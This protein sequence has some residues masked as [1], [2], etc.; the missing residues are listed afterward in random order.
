V[1]LCCVS[2]TAES[3]AGSWRGSVGRCRWTRGALFHIAEERA[4]QP[5]H[6]AFQTPSPLKFTSNA[7]QQP[8]VVPCGPC[9]QR[10]LARASVA[11]R[12]VAGL[13]ASSSSASHPVSPFR[14]ACVRGFAGFSGPPA[15]TGPP[16]SHKQPYTLWHA[17]C[18]CLVAA[19][20]H[21]R[22][23][24]LPAGPVRSYQAPGTLAELGE[25]RLLLATPRSSRP[26]RPPRPQLCRTPG[27]SGPPLM[28]AAPTSSGT[29]SIMCS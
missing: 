14:C 2:S 12:P 1:L 20:A 6:N 8:R 4:P 17:A 23:L 27:R 10:C 7:H 21:H 29:D 5:Q 15:P 26:H 3:C 11:P 19:S 25:P 24:A 18:A 16:L 13:F 9:L 28:A 22:R